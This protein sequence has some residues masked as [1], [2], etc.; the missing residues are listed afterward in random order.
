MRTGLV[1]GVVVLALLLLLATCGGKK[2]GSGDDS[3]D[4]SP[5]KKPAATGRG[6]ATRLDV[7]A[8]YDSGKGWELSGVSEEYALAPHARVL[9]YLQRADGGRFR[10][11]A[12][13]VR[14]G[15]QAWAGEAW[16]P[17]SAAPGTVPRLAA[18]AKDGR[19]YFAT[20]SYGKLGGDPLSEAD[21]VLVVDL[22]EAVG[23]ARQ[24]VELPWEAAPS[25][26]ASG[27]GL[28]VGV[29]SGTAAVLDPETARTATY[30][31]GDLKYPKGCAGCRRLT[32]VVGVTSKGPL[33][34]GEGEFW[35]R[36]AWH[37][38]KAAPKGGVSGTA[39]SVSGDRVLARWDHKPAKNKPVDREIWAVHDGASGKVL[40]SAE[41][42]RPALRPGRYPAAVTSP[43]G[44]YLVAGQLAFDLEGKSGHCFAAGSGAKPV[45]LA[46]VGDSGVAYGASG[47]R[48]PEDALR[49]G[50]TPVSVRIAVPEPQAL[51][52]SARLPVHDLGEVGIFRWTDGRDV[53]H[54]VGYAAKN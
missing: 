35:V 15:K 21:R 18:V 5:P 48:S 8:A 52:G 32:E 36:G 9:T 54:L 22:Y 41:C 10:L 11:R 4:G 20:W 28:V 31:A 50:G 14:T 53:H 16:R 25:V 26:S 39:V 51:P 7:P 37:G 23:G 12:V 38:R 40:A 49:G 47:A 43:D 42:P 27:P 44:R 30:K 46:T 17:L 13:D 1:V 6:P 29:G 34:N 45:T 33:V 24:R 2:D 3:G 19:E